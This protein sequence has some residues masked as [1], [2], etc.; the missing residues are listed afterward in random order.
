MI[1]VEELR[2]ILEAKFPCP[3]KVVVV[4]RWC[5]EHL[6]VSNALSRVEAEI[7]EAGKKRR[8]VAAYCPDPPVQDRVAGLL[9]C[10]GP[11]T[12][13]EVQENLRVLY[14]DERFSQSS[15]LIS[16]QLDPR[17][18]HERGT[19][20]LRHQPS[21]QVES[22]ANGNPPAPLVMIARDA[23]VGMSPS[24]SVR[25]LLGWFGYKSRT[26]LAVTHVRHTLQELKLRTHPDF[27][28]VSLDNRVE[29][30]LWANSTHSDT[31]SSAVGKGARPKRCGK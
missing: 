13:A 5:R 10:L 1:P 31:E 14:P 23:L 19:Y 26:A 6:S 3:Q 27:A 8:I 29:F 17:I 28:N 9:A 15:L 11:L 12:L 20:R 2:E 7:F 22:P 18:E 24:A 30:S 4:E 21:S 16:L 25:E